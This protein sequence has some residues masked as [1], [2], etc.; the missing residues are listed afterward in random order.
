MIHFERKGHDRI[1]AYKD[2][3]SLGEIEL[4]TNPFHADTQYL[5][6]DH[7][8]LDAAV[9]RELFQGLFAAV[10]LTGNDGL[11]SAAA[12]RLSPCRRL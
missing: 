2:E 1:Q 8:E 5:L 10:A 6:L 12:G 7:M 11:Q 9:S 3:T 4:Y